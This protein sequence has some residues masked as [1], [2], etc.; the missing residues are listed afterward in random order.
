MVAHSHRCCG[1]RQSVRLSACTIFRF[2][3]TIVPIVQVDPIREI[4]EHVCLNGRMSPSM[5]CPGKYC[6]GTIDILG[7]RSEN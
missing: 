7:E 2:L 4:A 1:M 5:N 3:I 6:W